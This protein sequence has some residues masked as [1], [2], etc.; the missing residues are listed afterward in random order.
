[1]RMVAAVLVAVGL[2]SASATLVSAAAPSIVVD[3]REVPFDSPPFI[4]GG[5]T[6]VPVRPIFEALG[7]TLIWDGP[8]RTVTAAL[9]QDT[10]KLVVDSHDMDIDGRQYYVDVTPRIVQGR[11]FVPLRVVAAAL[12]CDVAWDPGTQTVT[13]NTPKPP[14]PKTMAYPESPRAVMDGLIAAAKAHD[15]SAALALVPREAR[16]PYQAMLG[17]LSARQWDVLAVYLSDAKPDHNDGLTYTYMEKGP[18]AIGVEVQVAPNSAGRY[19]VSQLF[20]ALP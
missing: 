13:V 14:N 1:M 2:I 16:N 5:R 9:G 18:P 8:T 17:G 6:F 3:G 15:L 20:S 11:A 12:G 19:W 10:V 7:A 4:E